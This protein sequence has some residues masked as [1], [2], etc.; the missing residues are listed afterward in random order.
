MSNAKNNPF[1]ERFSEVTA[2]L[3][4]EEENRT[5]LPSTEGLK[6]DTKFD[7]S[8]LEGFT[9]PPIEVKGVADKVKPAGVGDLR[10][11]VDLGKLD[12]GIQKIQK[13]RINEKIRK[14]I[15]QA[16]K[17]IAQRKFRPAI[18]VLDE[19]LTADSTSAQALYL[20]AYCFYG[21]GDYDAALTHL[22]K[23]QNNA[24]DPQMLVLIMV[25]R[26]VC[27]RAMTVAFEVKL[28]ALIE[29]RRFAEALA[30]V[31]NELRRQPSNIALLYHRCGVLFIMG[32]VSEAKQAALVALQRVGPE[33]AGLFESM[34]N[35][36]EVQENQHY[37]EA[38]RKALRRGDSTGALKQLQSCQSVLSGNE[39][40]E[41]IRSYIEERNPRGFFSAIFSS[42]KNFLPLSEPIREKLLTWLFTEEI[43]A[44]VV[45]MDAG[46]FEHASTTFAA[47][48]KIDNRC[49]TICYLHGL[50]IF[51]GFQQAVQRKDKQLD[52]DRAMT[53]L[54][55]SADLF[56]RAATDPILAQQSQNLRQTVLAYQTQLQEVVRERARR[57]QE[58][59]PVNELIKDF[60]ALMD[61]LQNSP[62]STVNALEKAELT[63]RDL[64]KRCE[65]LRR[66]RTKEQG[67][68]LL[69]Q[70]LAAIV[71]NLEQVDQIRDDL[72]K[73]EQVQLI[74]NCV[75]SFNVMMEHFKNKPIR[76][77]Q[78]LEQARNMVN[79]I[80]DM[81][82]K[83]RAGERRGSEGLRVLDQ[84]EEAI[85]N[86]RRQLNA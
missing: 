9:S 41:A 31:E 49:R 27:V 1:R 19:A 59:K 46:K 57:E 34:I 30:L 61:S 50:S 60:N 86:S 28:D 4:H 36:I 53:L 83:A 76:N 79:N 69:D 21:L 6:L 17:L 13:Q 15:E 84:L 62:I 25:L 78:E 22:D 72:H 5:A 66:N 20:K 80:S 82:H 48:N 32:K 39:Q 70:I 38:A 74:N 33:N 26:A 2:T 23:S 85:R 63:F 51:K 45:A 37:L 58:A 73:N 64:R 47:A 56:A 43:T 16:Q 3:K 14:W 10:I 75:T 44:G 68:E 12:E 35:Q 42:R 11:D 52:L 54:E 67:C 55:T 8:Q 71:R 29:K 77:M 81:V 24:R 40:Y 18:K 7:I 65:K